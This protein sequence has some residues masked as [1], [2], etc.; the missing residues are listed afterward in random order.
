[1]E[2]D[3]LIIKSKNNRGI[4]GYKVFSVRLKEE[5]V[6]QIDDLAA[7]TGY[8]RNELIRI[9]LEYAVSHCEIEGSND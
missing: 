7:K 4:D 6:T 5:L 2:N 3:N 9:L 8:S 1:M